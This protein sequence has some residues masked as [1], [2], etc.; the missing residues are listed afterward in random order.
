MLERE[1][2]RRKEKRWK[3]GMSRERE[4]RKSRTE[5]RVSKEF[6]EVSGRSLEAGI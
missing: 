5:S 4:G 6:E 1:E 3:K 2:I